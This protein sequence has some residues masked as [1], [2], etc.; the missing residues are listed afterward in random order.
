MLQLPQIKARLARV[1]ELK[2]GMAKEVAVW[3]TQ[4]DPLLPQGRKR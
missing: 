1:E 3:Q 4:D 2:K